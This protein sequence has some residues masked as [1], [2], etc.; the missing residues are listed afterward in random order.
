MATRNLLVRAG[1]DASG[2]K[3]GIK[4]ANS[5]LS[6]FGKNA[7]S[8]MSA[9][10]GGISGYI[11]KIGKMLAGAF[12]I[13]KL[14][15]F[16]KE[17]VELGSNLSE[18]QNVVDVTFGSMSDQVNKFAQGALAQFGLSETAAKKYTST[19]GAMLKSMGMTTGQALTMSETITGLSADMASFY[20]LDSDTAFEKIRAGIS[21][22][23]EPLKQLGINMSVANMQAYAMSQGITTAYSKMSQAEQTLL[24]YNYL[25][26][27]TSDAQGDFARTS[28][29]WANQTRILAMQ[30]DALKAEIGQGLIAAL[31]PV[32]QGLNFLINKLRIAAG[33]F[34]SFM[35]LIFGKQSSGG[36]SG[37]AEVVGDTT[38]IAD[39]AGDA[40]DSISGIGDSAKKAGDTAKKAAKG[41]VASFDELHQLTEKTDNGSGS[42][43]SDGSGGANGLENL[44]GAA[45][46]DLGKIEEGT[47]KLDSLFDGMLERLKE[48]A[49][50]FNQGFKQGFET[51]D[52]G[53][54][55]DA[56][57]SVK[58]GL[59]AIFGD[60]DVLDAFNNMVDSFALS[61]GKI[62]GSFASIGVSLATN[63]IGG[64]GKYL[65]Q[66][67][68]LIRN[69]LINIFNVSGE[70]ADIVGDFAVTLADIAS[71][72]A[73]DDAQQVTAN[74]I[75]IFLNSFLGATELALKCGRDILEC[76]TRPI[77]ENKDKIKLALENSFS[78]MGSFTGTLRDMF[79]DIFASLNNVYD[80]YI[81]PAFSNIADGISNMLGA[82]L[83]NYNKYVVPL[84]EKWGDDFRSLYESHLKP[85]FDKIIELVGKLA[86]CISA[87]WKNTLSP[88]VEWVLSAFVPE[89]C[90]VLNIIWDA[91]SKAV[92]WIADILKDVITTLNGVLDF[93]TGV[94]T[95]DWQKCWNAI[96]DICKSIG[97]TAYDVLIGAL[98]QIISWL[99]GVFATAWIS[100]REAIKNAFAPLATWFNTCVVQPTSKFFNNL[101]SNIKS[102]A[103]SAWNGIK[104]SWN[105]AS[106][107]FNNTVV[108]PVKN[109]FSGMWNSISTKCSN[110]FANIKQSAKNGIN[111]MIGF[112]N[113]FINGINS[114]LS[115][116]MPEALGG[117]HI[118]FDIPKIPMLARGGVVD[119][120]TVALFGEAGAEAVVP[121]EN[122][123]EWTGKVAALLA[124]ALM[125][126]MN[127]NA[128]NNYQQN[129]T[130]EMDGTTFART[131]T[132]VII[133]EMKRLG[134][135]L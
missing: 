64:F 75:A 122:N 78:V 23:T 8:S 72:L 35:E 73:G 84:L 91:V 54:F 108:N 79:N 131:I 74:I 105:N 47:S 59:K 37:V 42:N 68:N 24:R 63:L 40:S 44:G 115:F 70:I 67:A 45:D 56:L 13:G 132:P 46:V 102:L 125:P 111:G 135:E 38:A 61:F 2:M 83:D 110:A 104:T 53:A 80:E 31:T 33:Y 17:C 97:K 34:R 99:K 28:N 128:V 94:F 127:N 114:K 95:Q 134:V 101:W 29:S 112:L 32:V 48:I 98:S 19:M 12:A 39:S 14:I 130:L 92:G 52:I 6:A 57:Q 58:D 3:S 103:N 106:S 89:I 62:I 69:R 123:T 85:L 10:S 124:N 15:K 121:L 86:Q 22:E 18:V 20:N 4:Q 107:W 76:I 9:L 81:E 82:I 26:S 43:G 88:L 66:N 27:V 65:N 113:S 118:G 90:G 77:E 16:G 36:G 93:L 49:T 41:A 60:G 120:P 100:S 96:V 116:N 87:I 25:L 1:F 11:G 21:G 50:L 133:K 109:A 126:F 71:V 119:D 7:N 129:V 55:K 117:A 5:Q 30:F 51:A